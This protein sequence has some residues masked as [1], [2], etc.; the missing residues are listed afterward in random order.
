MHRNMH[1][2]LKNMTNIIIL[3][4]ND[5]SHGLWKGTKNAVSAV[6]KD[7]FYIIEVITKPL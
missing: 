7:Q 2:C 6:I 3:N 5:F 1:Q 4:E